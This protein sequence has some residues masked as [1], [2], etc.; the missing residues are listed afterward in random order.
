MSDPF[1]DYEPVCEPCP[2]CAE[3][4]HPPCNIL[5]IH[6]VAWTLQLM[7]RMRAAI[8]AGTFRQMRDEVLNVWG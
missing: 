5:C 7:A 4:N 1:A 3:P 8:A 6:N 2:F